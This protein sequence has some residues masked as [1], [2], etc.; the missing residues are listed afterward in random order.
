MRKSALYIIAVLLA[1]TACNK[2]MMESQRLGSI[3]LAL[4][5]HSEVEVSTRADN[6]D[7]STFLVD[8][9]GTTYLNQ[10]YASERYVYS[11]MPEQVTIPFGNYYVTAQSCDE[12]A[13]QEGLGQVWYHGVSGELEVMSA[14]P[15]RASVNCAMING[16]VTMTIDESFHEDFTAVTVEVTAGRTVNLDETMTVSPVDMYFNTPE[17]GVQLV[18]TVYGTL[19]SSG[20]KLKYTNVTSPL[21]LSPAKWAKITVRSNHN[22]L[23]GPEI[24]V[25]GEMDNNSF[26]EVID[27]S[28]GVELTDGDLQLPT[29]IVNTDIDDATVIECELEI[30]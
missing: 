16:K 18:Y 15:V 28:G 5:S 22:G 23:V 3:S 27:P 20:T 30:I 21:T 14:A 17:D 24:S 12:T 29:I 1:A 26:T 25:D 13:A 6:V 10:T 2:V 7:C 11:Q 4:S 9:S 19:K 8:I